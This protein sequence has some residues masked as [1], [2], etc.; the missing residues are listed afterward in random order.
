MVS[1]LRLWQSSAH[2]DSPRR[3]SRTHSPISDH[4][5]SPRS[6]LEDLVTH[7]LTQAVINPEVATHKHLEEDILCAAPHSPR[8]RSYSTVRRRRP[9][10]STRS[11][12]PLSIYGDR[13]SPGDRRTK[14]S[15]AASRGRSPSRP[16]EEYSDR[17]RLQV[18]LVDCEVKSHRRGYQLR[19]LAPSIPSI[20]RIGTNWFINTNCC[21]SLFKVGALQT[22]HYDGL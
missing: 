10:A 11:P 12:S 5:F 19:D 9:R 21:H 18:I 1:S 4:Q 6:P 7:S 17:D 20:A 15:Q 16:D 8:S 2:C 14:P 3:R 22:T 13:Y